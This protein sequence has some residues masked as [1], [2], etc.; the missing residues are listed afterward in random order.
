MESKANLI[1]NNTE[2]LPMVVV[3]VARYK[4]A[5]KDAKKNRKK[6]QHFTG[7][8]SRMSKLFSKLWRAV[9]SFFY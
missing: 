1:P 2:I 5:D 3:V 9:E 8:N 4:W 7:S 6:Q